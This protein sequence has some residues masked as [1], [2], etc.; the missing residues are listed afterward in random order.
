MAGKP[1][2]PS[3]V[4]WF[5]TALGEKDSVPVWIGE[6][7]PEPSA[8]DSSDE[9]GSHEAPTELRWRPVEVGPTSCAVD[10]DSATGRRGEGNVQVMAFV[11]SGRQP[12]ALPHV[13]G[14]FHVE[15]FDRSAASG[16]I[17]SRDTG[18]AAMKGGLR[19][20]QLRPVDLRGLILERDLVQAV[21][22]GILRDSQLRPEDLDGCFFRHR[23]AAEDYILCQIHNNMNEH[24]EGFGGAALPGLKIRHG[25]TSKPYHESEWTDV[26]YIS[27]RPPTEDEVTS[28][29]SAI[30]SERCVSGDLQRRL[31]V[32]RRIREAFRK[33]SLPKGGSSGEGGGGGGGG[34]TGGRNGGG[35][36]SG[37]GGGGRGEGGDRDVDE[38][39]SLEQMFL[40]STQGR[41]QPAAVEGWVAAT[42]QAAVSRSRAKRPRSPS[43]NDPPYRREVG[44]VVR[45]RRG[46]TFCLANID[47]DKVR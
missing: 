28:L 6:H 41:T 44:C 24:S 21:M 38:Q 39:P 8:G 43:R 2:V 27:N 9:E 35:G 14:V 34:G 19:D 25:W 20:A 37:E 3:D 18:K 30:A 31:D 46:N 12:A 29:Y 10:T 45:G 32:S 40:L 13:L 36:S 7:P 5:L 26:Q 22:K 17:L 11:P 42:G 23:T 4:C 1:C 47:V 16:H 15:A 33:A